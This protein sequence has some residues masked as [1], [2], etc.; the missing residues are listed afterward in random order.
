[1]NQPEAVGK[2]RATWGE[3]PIWWNDHLLYVDIETH[4]II[5]Y[6]PESGVE[7]VWDVEERVGC[8]VPR[9]N[10][11]GWVMA[12]DNGYSFYD[13]ST[14]RKTQLADPEPDKKPQNRFNDGKCDPAGRFWAGTISTIRQTGDARLYALLPN[15]NVE[16]K[17]GP[18]T[19]SN[20]ICWSGGG[21]TMYYIDTPTKK[22]LAFDF[23]VGTGSITNPRPII[24]TAELGIDGSP[25][26]MTIDSLGNLWVAMCHGGCVVCFAP[27]SGRDLE[28]IDFPCVETTAPA[29]GGE[30]L[31]TLYVTT[32]I[33]KDLHEESGGRLFAVKPGVSG[34]SSFAFA[35]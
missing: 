11:E 12:G 6:L 18:V 14:H 9:Q 28:R 33:K 35:G 22:I 8:V 2:Y 20:G 32:G 19:N 25:D 34:V 26:G 15:M 3:G 13:P 21:D 5:R 17:F 16:E 4:R 23:E 1:M 30:N 27:E 29:F 10:A 7:E 31:E 24:D